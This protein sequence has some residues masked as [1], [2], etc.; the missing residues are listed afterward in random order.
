MVELNT[1]C[2]IKQGGSSYG[3]VAQDWWGIGSKQAAAKWLSIGLD[4][5][6]T[7]VRYSLPRSSETIVELTRLD[8]SQFQ[9]GLDSGLINPDMK[10]GDVKSI[11]AYGDLEVKPKVYY[12]ETQKIRE[13]INRAHREFPKSRVAENIASHL[14]TFADRFTR[15]YKDLMPID[16]NDN[17]EMVLALMKVVIR[18]SHPDMG[19]SDT[20]S[21]AANTLYD[22]IKKELK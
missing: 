16:I 1:L 22:K 2:E 9:Y 19:G 21:K 14:D 20:A 12:E 10:R 5:K 3:R 17:P 11:A 15:E 8:D 18:Y 6:C 13:A 4:E 7:A